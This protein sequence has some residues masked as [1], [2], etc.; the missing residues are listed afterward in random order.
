VSAE[1]RPRV[2]TEAD[3]PAV[4]ETLARAFERGPV[5]SWATDAEPGLPRED[6]L[7]ALRAVFGFYAAAVLGYGWIRVSGGVEAVALWIPPGVPGMPPAEE[8]RFPAFVRA[9]MGEASAERTFAA[10][11]A[12]DRV[13]PAEPPH[14]F[15]AML[16][17]HPDH[18][19]HG[20]GM[21]LLAANLEEFDATGVP[22]FLETPNPDNV[23]R[24]ERVG[25]HVDAEVD[26]L[27]GI[28][29]TQMWRDAPTS[30]PPMGRKPAL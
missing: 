22:A 3:L 23:P 18:A 28:R 15:L 7:A 29:S 13:R 1:L 27:A 16:G 5:W 14:Y 24:Y 11:E 30:D 2:A 12:F 10:M 8:E 21:R 20:Y 17:T 9:S 26:L 4:A 25:F 6:R 19:G